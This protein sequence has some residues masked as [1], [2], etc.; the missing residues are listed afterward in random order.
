MAEAEDIKRHAKDCD[1]V[2]GMN[3]TDHDVELLDQRLN[4]LWSRGFDGVLVGRQEAKGRRKESPGHCPADVCL[5]EHS[6]APGFEHRDC[7]PPKSELSTAKAG[8]G[9]P[10]D[11]KDLQAGERRGI[12]PGRQLE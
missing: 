7:R 5:P 3:V 9:R 4:S 8:G 11:F 6:R 1:L 2:A 12:G 10:A